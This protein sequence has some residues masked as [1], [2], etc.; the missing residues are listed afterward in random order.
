LF[1]AS[2]CWFL[3]TSAPNGKLTLI[4]QSALEQTEAGTRNQELIT[5]A[6]E[7]IA[8]GDSSTMRVLPYHLPLVATRGKGCRVWDAD[9]KQYI[10]LNMAFGPLIFGHC[11]PAVIRAVQR[12]ISNFGSQLGFPTEIT[13]RV[14]EK[15]KRLYPSIELL[16]FANSGTEAL[17]S[18][19]RL[20]RVF[21]GREKIV[22]FEGHYHGW[23]E[24]LF[25]R[26]HAPLEWLDGRD[27]GP[28]FP[29]T[30]GMMH[31]GPRDSLV[32]RWNNLDALAR[33]LEANQGEV[34]AVI[35][36][37]VM[38]NAGVIPPQPGYLEQARLL[39][40]DHGA[41]LIFDEVI[42]GMRVAAGGAQELYGVEPDITVVS[43]SI[44]GG[45]PVAAFGASRE[46]MEPIVS[47]QLFHGGVYS[48][49]AVVMAATEA[50]LDEVLAH[51]NA[52]YR[53]MHAMADRL[54]VGLG[55][56]LTHYEIPHVVQHVGPMLSLLLMRDEVHDIREYRDVRE[57][58]DFERFIV[59]QHAMQNAGVYFHPNQFEPM[60]LS[61]AHGPE[62]IDAA[63]AR[64]E[65]VVACTDL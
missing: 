35:M 11:P 31:G 3:A 15:L 42:T 62:D 60:F 46:I 19:A 10:D 32:V 20:A 8:G 21:T 39:A 4:R 27:Y 57:H 17:A 33:C 6:R 12:Q 13:T 58:C 64:F 61:T 40:H 7:S 59:L 16:R 47:G 43:K 18:T 41:L 48:G 5:R 65:Q 37:P 26:Y 45:Y 23:S 49:N 50:V 56:V 9:D 1:Y 29:G 44:G 63:L 54:A 30:P 28:A 38:G 34:A 25:N 52:I 14:A 55:E 2:S 24:A 22:Q 53:H 36:E 51:G